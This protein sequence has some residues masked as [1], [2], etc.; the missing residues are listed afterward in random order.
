MRAAARLSQVFAPAVVDAI[1]EL[2]DGEV[3]ERLRGRVEQGE[4][5]WYT[6]EEAAERLGC[7]PKAVRARVARGRLE[8]RHQGRRLYVSAASV[9]AA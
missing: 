9:D 3:E 7:S 5:K 6:T 2:V 8:H 1:V 4:R